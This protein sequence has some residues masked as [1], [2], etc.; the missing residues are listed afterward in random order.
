L[1]FLDLFDAKTESTSGIDRLTSDGIHLTAAGHWQYDLTLAEQLGARLDPLETRVDA[2]TGA[3]SRPD[4]ERVRQAVIAKNRFW[5]AYSR[6]TNW[7]FLDGDRTEQ[8]SSRDYRNPKIRWFPDEMQ[9]FVP[10]IDEQE[11]RIALLTGPTNG[12]GAAK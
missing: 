7:A 12:K 4:W 11:A 1:L 2:A 10:L 6:P 8:P 9:K 3:L 5:F